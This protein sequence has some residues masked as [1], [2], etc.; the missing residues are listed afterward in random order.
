ML[1]CR[2]LVLTHPVLT[3]ILEG[4]AVEALSDSLVP[5]PRDH[6]ALDA[7]QLPYEELRNLGRVD[8][9]RAR[10]TQAEQFDREV[11]PRISTGERVHVVYFGF[12]PIP[13]AVDLGYRLGLHRDVT[14]HQRHHGHGGWRW[15]PTRTAPG[16]LLAEERTAVGPESSRDAVLRVSTRR[17]VSPRDT[18]RLVPWPRVEVDVA[19]ARIEKDALETEYDVAE[20]LGAVERALCRIE[21]HDGVR[22]IHLFAAI[23]VG[24]AFGIGR[25]INP[26]VHPLHLYQYWAANEV[27]YQH[28]FV[29]QDDLA[30]EPS[31]VQHGQPAA[32][33]AHICILNAPEDNAFRDAWIKHLA[34]AERAGVLSAWHLGL[35]EPGVDRMEHLRAEIAG[36]DALLVLLS[37]DWLASAEVAMAEE[38]L[39]SNR[40]VLPLPVRACDWQSTPFG[41]LQPLLENGEPIARPENDE[42]LYRAAKRLRELVPSLRRRRG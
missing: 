26:S 32:D 31:G 42:A 1:S 18:S 16:P 6:V 41:A 15:A 14:I 39:R 10:R 30:A 9:A 28:A 23:P 8:W 33:G 38:R 2:V 7:V 34:P 35:L 22:A 40:P 37:A 12:A 4:E 3:P 20:V 11:R 29:L 5:L 25:L 36:C 17:R 21:E 19:T 13:L 27:P 24:L